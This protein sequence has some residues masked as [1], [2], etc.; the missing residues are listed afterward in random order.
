MVT[1]EDQRSF[2]SIIVIILTIALSAQVIRTLFP[3]VVFYPGSTSDVI[4]RHLMVIY[5]LPFVAPFLARL[6]GAK[7]LLFSC[8][9]GLALLRLGLQLTS[10]VGLSLVLVSTA[11]VLAWIAQG[12]LAAG[13]L[14]LKRPEWL[15][16]AFILGLS[17][18][19]ALNG[20]F[21]TWDY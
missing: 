9:G 16:T 20:A 3:I 13:V 19:A 4:A 18:D 8:I 15:P 17:L 21:L 10:S 7:R 1:K 6:V 12:L 5:V 11:V 2:W 14:H